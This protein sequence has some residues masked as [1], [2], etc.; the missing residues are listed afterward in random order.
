MTECSNYR[1]IS[2]LNQDYKLFTSILAKC[3]E[4]ILLDIIQ[5]DQTGFIKRR[6]IQ[7][8]VRRT[9]H[10]INNINKNKLNAVLLGLDAEK[11]FDS[12]DWLFLYKLLEKFQ[13]HRDFAK[14]IQALYYRP[15]ATIQIN[16]GLSNQF[17]L[18]RGCCQGC[19]LS[20]LLFALFI[21]PLSQW[22]KQN[23]KIKGIR[24]S[25]EEHKIALFADDIMIYLA[26]PCNSLPE[27]L[28]TLKEYSLLSGYKLNTQDSNSILQ[29]FP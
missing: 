18:E 17:E 7:D 21:E 19:P 11:A 24:V 10:I 14:V 16:G 3:L 23:E 22:I 15:T 2:L 29:L 20:P 4:T 6:Q 1:P 27:L 13:F 5:L 9:V 26:D 25:N 28:T 8:N 12:V